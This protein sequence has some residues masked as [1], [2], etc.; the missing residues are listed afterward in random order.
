[1]FRLIP[2]AIARAHRV[3]IMFIVLSIAGCDY[4]SGDDSDCSKRTLECLQVTA[5]VCA[6]ASE[7]SAPRLCSNLNLACFQENARCD[8]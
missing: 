3:A 6:A 5:L 4:L 2:T 8:N 1:M 7:Q